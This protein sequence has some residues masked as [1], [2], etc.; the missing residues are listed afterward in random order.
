MKVSDYINS[1]ISPAFQSLYYE[2]QLKS[3]FYLL[4]EGVT[5]AITKDGIIQREPLTRSQVNRAQV[6]IR[7][8]VNDNRTPLGHHPFNAG[9]LRLSF[10]DCVGML[11]CD[12][13]IN[14][15]NRANS[16]GYQ[17]W[18]LYFSMECIAIGECSLFGCIYL[19]YN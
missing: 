18:M 14:H 8:L 2:I 3:L 16:G 19:L 1:F 11:G 6:A 13:C 12:G 9:I 15:L 10:H 4:V 7:K 17:I 5:T